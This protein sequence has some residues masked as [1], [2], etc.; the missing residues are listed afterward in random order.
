MWE[1]LH[2]KFEVMIMIRNCPTV[3]ITT[4]FDDEY[5]EY[6]D[7]DEDDHEDWSLRAIHTE[8]W[9]CCVIETCNQDMY[10]TFV[11]VL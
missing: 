7:E 8:I 3:M 5:D 10:S 1:R 11:H 9:Q 4:T 6:D 2:A